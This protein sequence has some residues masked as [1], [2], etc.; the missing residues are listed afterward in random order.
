MRLRERA[1][2]FAMEAAG[3]GSPALGALLPAVASGVAERRAA[4]AA[5]G[6]W[7]R[8][9]RDLARPLVW[10]H[11]A[12]AG[13]LIAAEEVLRFVRREE[14][15]Q[16]V[17]TYSSPSGAPAAAALEPDYHGHPPFDAPRPCRRAAEAVRPDA[18]VFTR[19]DVWPHLALAA[20]RAGAGTGLINATV[21]ADSSR[22][23]TA[24]RWLLSPAYGRLR[25]VGAASEADAERLL[26]LGVRSDVVR[27][28]GDGAFDRAVA[29]HRNPSPAA[30]PLLA[31]LTR[32]DSKRP[33]PGDRGADRPLRLV[34][35][36]TWPEDEEPLLAGVAKVERRGCP[37][38]LVLV[39]HR[40]EP[41]SVAALAGR[42]AERL[43]RPP[44]LWSR[45]DGPRPRGESPLPLIVDVVGILADLY[46]LA[47]VAY[48]GGGFGK[49]GLHSVVEPAA[50]GLPV[51]F[52]PQGARWE[53]VELEERG[54][55]V[56]VSGPD[57]AE[58]LE[59]LADESV[60]RRMGGAA[61]R[62]VEERCGGAAA[63][64][65]LVLELLGA[66]SRRAG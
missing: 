46:G 33:E 23:R 54:G 64:A 63:G 29:R 42:C 18:L 39:P 22:L 66:R 27:V 62:Y 45:V 19:G 15:V 12:S 43:G 53:A 35:G 38:E 56:R 4:P 16:V 61:R 65:A 17:A 47:D 7:A 1:Y 31:W 57:V 37:V 3:A 11:G 13:E 2:G 34:A 26:R 51:L 14:P 50:A 24:A 58:T 10:L 41:E 60:R 21:A 8:H 59:R 20:R 9:G 44:K 55:A 5:I 52:G 28:T 25:R 36:S 6:E 30:R 49:G 40:P 48:V 32:E